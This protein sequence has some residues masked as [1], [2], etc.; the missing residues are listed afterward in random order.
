MNT[1]IKSIIDLHKPHPGNLIKPGALKDV[2]DKLV[3]VA[4]INEEKVHTIQ[5]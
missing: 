1:E 3:M 4:I 5:K 2:Y